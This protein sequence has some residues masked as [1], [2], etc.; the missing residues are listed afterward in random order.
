MAES[1]MKES[2]PE[3]RRDMRFEASMTLEERI[4]LLATELERTRSDLRALQRQHRQLNLAKIMTYLAGFVVLALMASGT[5]SR[6]IAQNEVAR[7]IT[8]LEAPVE[9]RGKSGQTIVQI[10]EDKGRYGL[11]I[12]SPNVPSSPNGPSSPGASLGLGFE[13]A[14]GTS[15]LILLKEGPNFTAKLGRDGLRLYKTNQAVAYLGIS[16]GGNGELQ[17]GNPTGTSLVEAGALDSNTGV[18]RVY[19]FGATPIPI[20]TF[21]R[22]MNYKKQ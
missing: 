22:G 5:A 18:V 15:G 1:Q 7:P 12:Y 9:I 10:G 21:L 19:P 3:G 13:G 8:I 11:N 2:Q 17:L 16:A 4:K 6:S 14:G 20:P